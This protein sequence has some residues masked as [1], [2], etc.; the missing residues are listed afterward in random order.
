MNERA[1]GIY[2]RNAFTLLAW[3]C[4]RR[5]AAATCILRQFKVKHFCLSENPARGKKTRRGE[6]SSSPFP[7]LP[8]FS[9]LPPSLSL[10]LPPFFSPSI[11]LSLRR[12]PQ[13]RHKKESQRA[14]GVF[15]PSHRSSPTFYGL[16]DRR[17]ARS[18]WWDWMGG[19][20]IALIS[21]Q[22]QSQGTS[23]SR[24]GPD[25]WIERVPI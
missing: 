5:S 12:T 22:H 6:I 1:C 7:L 21:R 18:L 15:V 11:H 8:F 24:V 25:R 4:F 14:K 16:K 13:N 10:P 23:R 3:H 9:L 19:G 20:H 2:E 17:P